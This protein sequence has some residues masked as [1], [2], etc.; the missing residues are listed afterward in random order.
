MLL[1]AD[2]T[3]TGRW[4]GDSERWGSVSKH[5]GGLTLTNNGNTIQGYGLIG[6]NGLALVNQSGT[7]LANVSGQTLTIC[8]HAHKQRHAAR[9]RRQHRCFGVVDEFHQFQR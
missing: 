8:R 1:A 4:N 5:V 7:V 3:L 9:C 6:D 2:T